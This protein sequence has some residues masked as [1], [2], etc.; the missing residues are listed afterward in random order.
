MALTDLLDK[1]SYD[2]HITDE[3]KIAQAQKL[4]SRIF[5]VE[6]ASQIGTVEMRNGRPT[7]LVE[8]NG[9]NHELHYRRKGRGDIAWT[10][11]G[12]TKEY[13]FGGDRA[14]QALLEALS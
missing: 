4:V 10:V 8:H 12:G 11:D 3:V 7:L 14:V 13:V 5:G 9:A 1:P 2:A 6:D